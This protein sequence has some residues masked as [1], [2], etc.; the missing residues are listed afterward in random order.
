MNEANNTQNANTSHARS[1]GARV[2]LFAGAAV[3]G[4]LAIGA[5]AIGG[6]ALWGDSQK[7]DD[8][9]LS[10]SSE[11]FEASTRA[12][13][14]ESID[15]DLNE[16]D[17]LVDSGDFGKVRL[18]VSPQTGKPVFVGI[19]AAADVNAYLRHVA[20]TRVTDIDW[21][22]FE[23][24][25]SPQ[26]GERRPAAPAGQDIWKASA[27]GAGP[28][29]LNWDV[30]DGDWSVVVMNADG[31]TGVEAD[32]SSGA[33]VPFLDELGWSALGAGG[34]LVLAAAGL[35]ALALR[36]PRNRPGADSPP[37][38]AQPAPAA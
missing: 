33:K 13:T 36:P 32:I 34:I 10:T 14:S 3:A 26:D 27:H 16:A 35:I 19:A 9:Y 23:A 7:D 30:E 28:Q 37:A 21:P 25:Y 6:V 12:M 8:G 18:D 38:I 22:Q 17:W 15:I 1:R 4:L 11:R 29:V 24:T 20:H 5:L 31:S 2:G